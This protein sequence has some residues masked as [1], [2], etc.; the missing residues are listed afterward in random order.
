RLNCRDQPLR[1]AAPHPAPH[2]ERAS[3]A[4]RLV[5]KDGASATQQPTSGAPSW[6]VQTSELARVRRRVPGGGGSGAVTQPPA[7]DR[8][9]A[10]AVGLTAGG[11]T[12]RCP[13]G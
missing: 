4:E 13:G 7:R 5:A 2:C 6:R 12:R 3:A 10:S 11:D 9:G 1:R 8:R